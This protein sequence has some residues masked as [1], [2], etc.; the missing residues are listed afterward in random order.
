[1]N[2]LDT[3]DT[4]S[5]SVI[6]TSIGIDMKHV[7][8]R[9]LPN[10]YHKYRVHLK[11]LD[12]DSRLLRFG[13]M[14]K[15]EMLDKL[16]DNFE[17]EPDKHIL[18][19]VED[20]NLDFIAIGHIAIGVDDIIELAFSVLKEAQ[21]QG[22]GDALMKRCIRYCRTRN[23]QKGFMVCLSH[24]KAIK[25]LC[26]KNRIMVHSECGESEANIEFAGPRVVTYVKEGYA[27]NSAVI[28]YLGKRALLPWTL[29][30]KTLDNILK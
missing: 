19:C 22:I 12:A 30:T 20:N 21:G 3:Q 27:I 24:N 7:V 6:L 17:K 15:E 14:V 16:C 29:M 25:H 5:T 10:E 13:F 9:V 8:R 11:A 2:A 1:M 4:K 18:F 26:T 28:D 23:I